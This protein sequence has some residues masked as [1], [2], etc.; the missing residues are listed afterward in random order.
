MHKK[1]FAGGTPP[2][3]T[4]SIR[5]FT[6]IVVAA[7]GLVSAACDLPSSGSSRTPSEALQPSQVAPTREPETRASLPSHGRVTLPEALA[8]AAQHAPPVVLAKAETRVGEAEVVAARQAQPFNPTLSVGLGR[9]RQANGTG[10]DAQIGL[11]QQLEVGGQRRKRKESARRFRELTALG[12]DAASWTVHADVHWA[13]ERALLAEQ[14]LALAKERVAVSQQLL[15]MAKR[16][17][18][19]GDESSVVVEVATAELALAQNSETAAQ[20]DVDTSRMALAQATGSQE[21][22]ELQ[23]IGKL[24]PPTLTKGGPHLAR[25]AIQTNPTL[26]KAHAA[27]R[28]AEADLA[29]ARR[30]AWPSPTVGVSFAR[31][32]ATS[33]PGNNNP[34]STIWMGTL[35][36]PIPSFARNQGTVAR[37]RAQV[38]VAEARHK[39]TLVQFNSMVGIA[40]TRV[41]AAAHRSTALE[42]GVVSAFERSLTALRRAYEVGELSFLEVAQAL[43]RLWAAREQA[44]DARA[45]Y[46]EAFAD[47]ERLVGPLESGEFGVVETP[48]ST[49]EGELR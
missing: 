22:A 44:L 12:L 8:F 45:D 9:R 4:P 7:S 18:A 2:R 30:N 26:K 17:V 21:P 41:D 28:V 32:G 10:L 1:T 15:E 36:V 24:E 31:E 3:R 13:F 19:V 33:T 39:T 11:Q 5:V 35:Q 42:T 38:R 23:P 37:S 40:A 43:Q 47:L 6:A 25:S 34:A 16:R 48:A 20:A 46:H 49:D 29:V 27:T 14:R